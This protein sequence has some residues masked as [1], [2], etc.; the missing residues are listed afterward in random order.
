M[1]THHS[2]RPEFED[3]LTPAEVG[4]KFRVD[5]KTVTRWAKDGKVACF[6][7][8]GGHRRYRAA[9]IQ[10]AIDGGESARG[11]QYARALLKALRDLLDG[12]QAVLLNPA[13]NGL[14]SVAVVAKGIEVSTY[15]EQSTGP[16]PE[17]AL[18]AAWRE[19]RS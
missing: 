14:Y 18:L 6:T 8:L 7:T 15:A 3:L 19:T 10:A 4:L 2:H 1:T 17:A 9:D 11:E 12:G 13:S 16:S 5:P